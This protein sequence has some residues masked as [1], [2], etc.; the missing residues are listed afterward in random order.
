MSIV[1]PVETASAGIRVVD[2]V[3]EADRS[4]LAEIIA[5][6]ADGR[7]RTNIGTVASLDAAIATF[8]SASRCKGKTIIELH[9]SEA[10]TA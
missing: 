9:K 7:L 8:T 1:G 4:Q 3:V 5:R 10:A 2:F 6:V